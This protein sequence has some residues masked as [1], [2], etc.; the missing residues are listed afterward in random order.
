M[1]LIVTELMVKSK[2][3]QEEL[4]TRKAVER[5]KGILMKE[6]ELSEE[7]AFRKMQKYSM[8]GSKSMRE[9]AGAIILTSE[10]KK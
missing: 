6:R 4:K 5:A 2:V 1:R 3:I 7:E 10:M 9:I 8:D